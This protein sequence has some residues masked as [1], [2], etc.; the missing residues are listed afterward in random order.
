MTGVKYPRH[1]YPDRLRYAL[2]SY[3]S[4][5]NHPNAAGHI[6]AATEIAG[7]LVIDSAE[8]ALTIKE[9]Q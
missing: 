1:F 6:P 8:D 2:A 7:W 5:I 3:M 4:R 9:Q